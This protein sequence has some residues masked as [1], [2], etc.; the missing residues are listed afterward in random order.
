[1]PGPSFPTTIAPSAVD[2]FEWLGQ[3]LPDEAELS[4]AVG[5]PVEL[6]E[7]ATPIGGPSDLRNTR[8]VISKLLEA[9][10]LGVVSALEQRTYSTTSVQAVTYSTEPEATYGVVLLSSPETADAAFTGM[11]E[12]WQR[13]D[14]RTVV[15]SSGDHPVKNLIH[16]VTTT[17]DVPSARVLVTSDSPT[18]IPAQV[19]RALGVSEDCIVEAELFVAGDP[20]DPDITTLTTD[21]VIGLVLTMMA[22]VRSATR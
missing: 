15:D 20:N 2:Q 17:Q 18:G 10:C 11:S 3:V 7:T 22:N 6:D 4:R 9:D 14:G 12:Q 21:N 5:H 19:T 1:M 13:C 16:Q 8:P